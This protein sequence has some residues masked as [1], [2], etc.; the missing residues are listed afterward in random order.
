MKQQM[1][2]AVQSTSP[3]E[4]EQHPTL[5]NV[6]ANQSKSYQNEN[7]N[8]SEFYEIKEE[9]MVESNRN[10]SESENVIELLPKS[11]RNRARVILYYLKPKLDSRKNII[12]ADGSVGSHLLDLLKF[13]LNQKARPMPDGDKFIELLITKSVPRSV[14]FVREKSTKPDVT[15][16]RA[17]PSTWL[18]FD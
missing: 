1:T 15:H 18:T 7:A 5:E 4:K 16:T 17:A 3:L 13:V 6:N 11:Y 8:Q 12:Y 2:S 9:P 10:E 14:Y